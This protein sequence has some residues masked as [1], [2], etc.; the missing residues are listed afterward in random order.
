MGSKTKNTKNI[1]GQNLKNLREA[2]NF[3]RKDVANALGVS[4]QQIHKYELGQN[5]PPYEHIS[6]LRHLYDVPYE[7]FFVDF[8]PTDIK[9]KFI[10]EDYMVYQ[11]LSAL[12]DKNLKKKIREICFILMEDASPNIKLTR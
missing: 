10:S 11:N 1:L 4:Y 12:K 5:R 7:A 9:A 8:K 2:H 6:T 3:S